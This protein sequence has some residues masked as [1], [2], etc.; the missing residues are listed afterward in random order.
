MRRQ[1]LL[2]RNKGCETVHDAVWCDTETLPDPMP[3]GGER[4]RLNFGYACYRRSPR[5]DQWT[6]PL[7]ARFETVDEFWDWIEDRLHG[8]CKLY[9]FAH[10]WAFDFPVLNGFNVLP[11][12]GWGLVSSVIE[13]PPIILK[14]RR[15]KQ[16]ICIVDT[17]NIWR[18][19]L[20]KLGKSIGLPKLEM[21]AF[22]APADEWNIYAHRDVEIIMEAC[23][24][25]WTFLRV[26][27]LGGFAPTL[28]AQAFRTFRHRF[29]THDIMIDNHAIGLPL[30]RSAV[31]GGRT[32]AFYIGKVPETIYKL[33]INSMY[34]AIMQAEEMPTKIIGAYKNVT[35]EE[36]SRWVSRYS[37]VAECRLHTPEPCY[38]MVHG[39]RLVFP[40]GEFAAPLCTPELEYALEHDHIESIALAA[41]YE[42]EPI[43]RNYVEWFYPYRLTCK[44][45]GDDVAADNAKLLLNSLYGKTGQRGIVYRKIDDTPDMECAQWLEV[46]AETN[47]V[48]RYRQYGGI[49]E[50][51]DE[52]PESRDSHPAIAAHVTAYARMRLWRLMLVAERQNIYYCDTDSLWVNEVGYRNLSPYLHETELGKLKLEGIHDDVEI[53]GAKDYTIDGKTRIKGIRAK[54]RQ[55]GR[56]IYEQEK[57]SSIK[58]LLRMGDLTAPVVTTQRKTLTRIYSKGRVTESGRVEPLFLDL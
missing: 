45:K 19:S 20:A 50:Q 43:F 44:E 25:W 37:V 55:L 21:P 16:T 38:G 49:I 29:M 32:E 7:W 8:K 1:H 34:P 18:M 22:G 48:R 54:A 36:L 57:F 14:Y 30:A 11:D 56:N 15:N 58:G 33:D 13:S 3:G 31:H 28:A 41:V 12:R 53:R 24:K 51:R 26:N 6:S 4:H 10:N 46:D 47:E 5:P 2:R 52:S 23:M 35:H 39:N 17:L 40:V 9:I 27:D 42:R